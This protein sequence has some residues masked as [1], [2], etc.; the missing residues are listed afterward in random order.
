[1]FC[2]LISFDRKLCETLAFR[3]TIQF[4]DREDAIR[5]HTRRSDEKKRLQAEKKAKRARDATE[6][7]KGKRYSLTSPYGH[8]HNTD[9]SLLRT[10][11]L[12]PEMTKIIHSLPL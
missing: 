3:L 6:K 10:V 8:L 2:I 4:E 1:M 9:T 7:E 5:E 11:R 12:V